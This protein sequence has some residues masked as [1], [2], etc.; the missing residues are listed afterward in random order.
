MTRSPRQASPLLALALAA[1]ALAAWAGMA[2]RAPG[3]SAPDAVPTVREHSAVTLPA[4]EACLDAGYLCR[5]LEEAD[6]FRILRWPDDVAALRIEVPPPPLEDQRL[7]RGLQQ[8]AIRGILAWQDA[9][10]RLTI[11]DRMAGPADIVVSWTDAVGG[12]R[13]GETRVE[14]RETN[15]VVTFTIPRFLLGTV[16]NVTGRTLGPEDLELVAVHEMGHA[17]GLNHSD[18]PGDVMY[19][20]KTA[21]FLTARDHRTVHA[22][23]RL[24]TGALILRE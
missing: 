9:P 11:N 5:E 23:Y 16:S 6:S 24:P 7:A 18:S 10:L 2:R 3:E 15:G 21:R 12:T 13:L 20:E 14:W 17:L 19:P 8:A 4:S 22:L 1:A